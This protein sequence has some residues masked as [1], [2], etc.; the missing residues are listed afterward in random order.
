MVKINNEFFI[1]ELFLNKTKSP[2][3]AFVERPEINAPKFNIF[4]K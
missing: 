3:P 2:N 1:E 4:F